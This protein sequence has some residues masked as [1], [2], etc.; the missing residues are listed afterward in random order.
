MS[1]KLP[2][3][4]PGSRTAEGQ[5]LIKN[6]KAKTARAITKKKDE[7]ALKDRKP[8]PPNYRKKK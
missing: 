5:K 8:L 6:K 4:K 3:F 2:L 7:E 1:E